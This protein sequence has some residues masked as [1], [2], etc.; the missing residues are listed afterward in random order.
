M[1]GG[2]RWADIGEQQRSAEGMIMLEDV[3]LE[4]NLTIADPIG[5]ILVPGL[6]QRVCVTPLAAKGFSTCEL[7]LGY[8]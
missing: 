4:H 2:E 6:E 7:R 8:F 1:G 3:V 5:G